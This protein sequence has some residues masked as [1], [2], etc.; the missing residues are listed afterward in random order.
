MSKRSPSPV[1]QMFRHFAEG[2]ARQSGRP[3][4]FLLAAVVVVIWAATGPLFHFGDTWQLVINTGT[5]I[6]TFLMVFLIQ[7]SQNRD[8][9][10]LQIKLDELIRATTAQNELLAVE[11]LDEDALDR[12]RAQYRAIALRRVEER[13]QGLSGAKATAAEQADDACEEVMAIKRELEDGHPVAAADVEKTETIKT[14]SNDGRSK[15]TTVVAT[16]VKART[17]KA[18]RAKRKPKAVALADTAP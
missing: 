13:Q 16:T 17:V 9:I 3:S 15:A 4:A 8:S 7:N 10:A 18:K 2:T 14:K 1:S 11:D 5:T 6:I 12:V